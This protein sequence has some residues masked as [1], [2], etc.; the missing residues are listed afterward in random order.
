MARN[1]KINNLTLSLGNS[2]IS[3]KVVIWNLPAGS[4]YT[5]SIDCPGCYAKKAQRIYPTVLAC[6]L[7]N[8]EASKQI[9]FVPNMI[10]A[11]MKTK[12][13]FVRIH[14]SG[15]FYS[16][17]YAQKWT[18]ITSQLSDIKFY[19]YTKS[20]YRP[21]GTNIN[22]VESLLPDGRINFGKEDFINECRNNGYEV[23]P[24]EKGKHIT[25]MED[26]T[27]CLTEKY[28]VFHIH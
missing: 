1:I 13:E 23:C 3:N 7:R 22:C 19:F 21:N 16:S 2:K 5:C 25:C 26:C 24:C 15:D 28:V 27:K 20:K 11:L 10:D 9:D 4:Q 18:D 12:A 14:E 8:W 6:R 17:A